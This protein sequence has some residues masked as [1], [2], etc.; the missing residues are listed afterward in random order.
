MPDSEELDRILEL[1]FIVAWAGEG[2][3][4]EPRQPWWDTNWIDEYGGADLLSRMVPRTAA[5][6]Q[7]EMAREAARRVD[8]KGLNKQASAQ[9][10]RSIFNL[11]PALDTELRE[12]L[13][14][15]KTSGTDPLGTLPGLA[16]TRNWSADA[17]EA[18]IGELGDQRNFEPEPFGLRLRGESPDTPVEL[19]RQLAHGLT[20]LTDAYPRPYALAG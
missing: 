13:F 5:W 14:E 6:A 2:G 1:Q 9:S 11:G 17:F 4:T 8:M 10:I 3:G 7:Y 18:F 16:M 12:R 19:I 20:P 15:L